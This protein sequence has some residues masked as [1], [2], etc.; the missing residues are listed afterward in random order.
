MFTECVIDFSISM[1]LYNILNF[2]TV[3]IKLIK[4]NAK[5]TIN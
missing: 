4:G 2:T 1:H 3:K 5:S